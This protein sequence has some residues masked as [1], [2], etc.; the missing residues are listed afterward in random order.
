MT[1]MMKMK[2][3]ARAKRP[4]KAQDEQIHID[5][6]LIHCYQ[7]CSVLVW[8]QV[9]IDQFTFQDTSLRVATVVLG[10]SNQAVCAV[11]RRTSQSITKINSEYSVSLV[12][13]SMRMCKNQKL[14]NI[15]DSLHGFCATVGRSD[16][17]DFFYLQNVDINISV[18]LK[19][20][21]TTG[22]RD[23]WVCRP[24]RK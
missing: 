19:A 20:K 24:C 5:Q 16:V 22:D 15:I 18:Q 6:L 12:V 4:L 1:M 23:Q 17:D 13:S 21:T 7:Q 8:V 9:F 10:V 3:M 14:E 11:N 2:K